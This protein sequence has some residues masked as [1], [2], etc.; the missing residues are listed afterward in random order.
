M[1]SAAPEFFIVIPAFN[2]AARLPKF[3]R[4]LAETFGDD[5][6]VAIQIVDDGSR[7]AD[8]D[9]CKVAA[10]DAGPLFRDIIRLEANEGKGAAILAGWAAAAESP[11][12]GF[13]D[14]DGAVSAETLKES[15]A[16]ARTRTEVDAWFGSRVKML[17]KTV[18]RSLLR[19]YVGRVFA[20]IVGMTVNPDVYDSQ[21]GLKLVRR[22]ALDRIRPKLAEKEFG[23][24]VDLLAGLVAT[25]ARVVENPVDWE[26]VAGSTVRLFRDSWRLFLATRRVRARWQV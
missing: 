18:A 21:C 20:T 12:V 9:A 3:V 2:E 25:G 15:I 22:E 6:T 26:D 14:A 11:W 1:P 19:H 4:E 8:F 24:D 13:V 5:P 23:F 17:G 7:D 10:D 16:L